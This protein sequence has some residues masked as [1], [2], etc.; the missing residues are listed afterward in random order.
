MA[1]AVYSDGVG[2]GNAVFEDDFQRGGHPGKWHRVM[3]QSGAVTTVYTGSNY[4][5]GGIMVSGSAVGTAYLSG[6][7]SVD[8]ATLNAN[9]GIYE[10]SIRSVTL[11]SGAV[12]LYFRNH[13]VR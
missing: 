2:Y 4:G 7:G 8:I 6:G 11:S 9:A 12:Y 5:V 13:L 10:F 3:S 1:T